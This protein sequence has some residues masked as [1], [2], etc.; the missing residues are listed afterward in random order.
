MLWSLAIEQK[1]EKQCLKKLY[2]IDDTN[3]SLEVET[4][5]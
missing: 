3:E 5:R 2:E 4:N 1:L